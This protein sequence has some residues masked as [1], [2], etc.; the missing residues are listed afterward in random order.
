MISHAFKKRPEQQAR[1]SPVELVTK[2]GDNWVNAVPVV[3][4]GSTSLALR[5]WTQDR[6]EFF[7]MGEMERGL[8]ARVEE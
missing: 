6:R 1:Y 8:M 4:A 7:L 3:V 5:G 2:H